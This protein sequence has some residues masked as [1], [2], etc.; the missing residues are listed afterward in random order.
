MPNQGVG[1]W[2]VAEAEPYTIN[3][4]F[5]Q[6]EEQINLLRGIG[7]NVSLS[8]ALHA[9]NSTT[10]G[11][12]L[13]H[14]TALTGLGDNDHPQY[15]LATA[16]TTDEA[17]EQ[18]T[19]HDRISDQL[20]VDATL[21]LT[22][23]AD[24]SGDA[25]QVKLA[26]TAVTPGTYGDA[27]NVSQ[28]TVDQ[29]GRLTAAANVAIVVTAT[30]AHD[31]GF[32]DAAEADV[33]IVD[34]VFVGEDLALTE[35]GEM[36]GDS[37]FLDVATAQTL[38]DGQG[39][40]AQGFEIVVDGLGDFGIAIDSTSR[41]HLQGQNR[42]RYLNSMAAA[43]SSVDLTGRA[44]NVTN[45]LTWDTDVFDTDGIHDTASNTSRLTAAHTGKYLVT[46]GFQIAA[47]TA[48]VA[49]TIVFALIFV[50]G[51]TYR[52]VSIGASDSNGQGG[53]AACSIVS[54]AAGDYVEL[55]DFVIATSGTYKISANTRNQFAMAYLGE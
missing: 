47:D 31:I 54:L 23:Q 30:E 13:D 41:L 18:A 27:T 12:K 34:Q 10:S 24:G 17:I 20:M 33:R 38:D 14:G 19:D 29:Q 49:P 21:T 36:P 44:V 16:I 50:N 5:R 11:G 25:V 6:I 43:R 9:H 37:I 4:V 26:D 35:P 51:T 7:V 32:I 55:Q 3:E 40:A 52:G 8:I 15:L 2:H 45:T 28:I 48:L 39:G 53:A 46:G 22:E 42:F 1:P